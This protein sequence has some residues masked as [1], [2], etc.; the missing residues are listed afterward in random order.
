MGNN[1]FK[2]EK[3]EKVR[4]F[5]NRV[6]AY[7]GDYNTK[8]IEEAYNADRVLAE[9]IMD[10]EED[11]MAD[12]DF[13]GIN[14]DEH[15]KNNPVSDYVQA[16]IDYVSGDESAK[17][18]MIDAA[19][20]ITEGKVVTSEESATDLLN[21]I[22]DTEEEFAEQLENSLESIEHVLEGTKID[23]WTEDQIELARYFLQFQPDASVNEVD[24]LT[25]YGV[26][27]AWKRRR[28]VGS[29]K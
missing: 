12:V 26:K 6:E 16:G 3:I 24:A 10:L 13:S 15:F 28:W 27:L 5:L 21:R 25:P 17:D 11:E 9:V 22:L 18:R 2:L 4:Q 29:A 8:A 1:K 20:R 7:A 14:L 23:S 19:S